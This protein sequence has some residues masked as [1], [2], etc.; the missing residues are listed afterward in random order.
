MKIGCSIVAAGHGTRLGD[1][2]A[3]FPKALVPVLGRPMLYYSLNAMDVMPEITMFSVAVP[4]DSKD[5]FSRH[6]KAWGFGHKVIVVAGGENRHDSVLNSLRAFADDPPEMMLIHDAARPCITSEMVVCLIADIDVGHAAAL[7]HPATDTLRE[8]RDGL[9]ISEIDRTKIAGLETPQLFPF[10]EILELHESLSETG[11]KGGVSDDTSLF[12]G[13]GKPVKAVFHDGNN[14]KV[15]YPE[16]IASVEGILYS[17]GWV[18][19]ADEE[20]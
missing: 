13:A 5:E 18:D 8:V 12:T 15:T 11:T 6:I 17:R 19:V 10:N 1:E 7:V 4:P 16:D 2:W 9:I 3:G 14:I 20:E